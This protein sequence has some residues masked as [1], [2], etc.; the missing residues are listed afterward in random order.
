MTQRPGNV[1][2]GSRSCGNDNYEIHWGNATNYALGKEIGS[3]SFGEVF[4]GFNRI[5]NERVVIKVLKPTRTA[6]IKREVSILESLRGGVHIM[7]LLDVVKLKHP[8]GPAIVCDYISSTNMREFYLSLS[9]EEIRYYLLSLLEALRFCHSHGIMH[10]DVKPSNI[11]VNIKQK[12]MQLI[13][14]GL[15]DYYLPGKA[16]QANVGTRYYK[17]PELLVG[18]KYY[19]YSVDLWSVGCMA[20]SMLFRVA[21]LFKGENDTDQ[22]NCI[23]EVLGTD[24]LY[25]YAKKHDIQ[26]PANLLNS[27]KFYKRKEWSKFV[28]SAN[29]H[30]LS[31]GCFDFLDKMLRYDH[32]ERMTAAEAMRHPFLS[33]LLEIE[34]TSGTCSASV[35][36]EQHSDKNNASNRCSSVNPQ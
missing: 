33:S 13:D 15:S 23:A 5:S 19:D 29:E 26:L 4:E 32:Q 6:R 30:L 31:P 24:G 25:E 36:P 10:R 12:R 27:P 16:Y 34:E 11:V 22:L 7:T 8:A 1:R 14:F 35:S 2:S 3:G 21:H 28:D 9:Y 20:A 18:Y 17:A